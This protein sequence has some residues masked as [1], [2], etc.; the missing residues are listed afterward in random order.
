VTEIFRSDRV[1]L[2]GGPV[3]SAT[4]LQSPRPMTPH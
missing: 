4:A 2:L 1:E 3:D